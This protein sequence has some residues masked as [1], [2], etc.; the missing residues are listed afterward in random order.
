MRRIWEHPGFPFVGPF[1]L[2]MG[3]LAFA[4]TLHPHAIYGVYPLQT[5]VVGLVL[6][7]LLPRLP[8]LKP[9]APLASVG[10]G[11]LVFVLWVGLDPYLPTQEMIPWIGKPRGEGF[12]PYLFEDRQ[13]RWGL[14][15]FRILGSAAVVPV[16]EE[17][18]WRGFVMRYLISENWREQAFG[19]Y[20]PLSFWVTT[21]LF[22]SVHFQIT[23][24]ILAG[25][26]YG[27]WFVRTRS[28]GSVMLAHAVTNLLLGVYVVATGR[29]YFW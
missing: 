22:A 13:I 24:A 29:W 27:G 9:A 26:L 12:N 7:A 2:F 10:I 14:I 19:R 17:L 28:L 5:L 8:T 21:L 18:F 15:F 16:M 4:Q 6:L 11:V 20:Q 25:I 23:L 1:A 3:F